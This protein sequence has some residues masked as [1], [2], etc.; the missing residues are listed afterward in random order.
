MVNPRR[1]KYTVPDGDNIKLKIALNG[2][3]NIRLEGVHT[4]EIN[5][6][7]GKE[8]QKVLR[9]ILKVLSDGK[10][11]SIKSISHKINSHWETTLKALEFL[12][13]VNLVKERKG[14]KTYKEERLFS[15][16]YK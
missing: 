1:T 5:T 8:A 9:N 7:A 16:I 3:K 4:P 6:A 13:E 14:S 11:Y 2:R 15:K 12:K 10:E